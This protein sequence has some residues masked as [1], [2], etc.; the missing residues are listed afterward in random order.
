MIEIGPNLTELLEVVIM[1]IFMGWLVYVV[2][3]KTETFR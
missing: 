1:A 3:A 2:I